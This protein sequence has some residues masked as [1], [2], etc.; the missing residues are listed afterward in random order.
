MLFVFTEVYIL[1]L[2]GFR[3][4]SHIICRERGKKGAFGNLGITFAKL[5]I[6]LFSQ[7]YFIKKYSIWKQNYMR[8]FKV[9]LGGLSTTYLAFHK[10]S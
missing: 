7:K 2:P 4:I 6:G 5:A 9:V 3:M 10:N 8:I 1:I